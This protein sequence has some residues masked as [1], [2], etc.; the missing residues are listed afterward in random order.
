VTDERMPSR[1][2]NDAEIAEDLK[3]DEMYVWSGKVTDFEETQ[4]NN[5]DWG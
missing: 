4:S 2:Q 5:N 3:K 1:N